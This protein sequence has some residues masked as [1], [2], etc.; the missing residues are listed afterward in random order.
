MIGARFY[1]CCSMAAAS[2]VGATVTALR[3]MIEAG[4]THIVLML[5][6]PYPEGI[7]DRLADEVVAQFA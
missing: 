1:R 5:V 6:H 3:P 2:S 7:V 4:A